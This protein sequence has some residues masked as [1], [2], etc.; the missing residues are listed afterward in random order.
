FEQESKG[1]NLLPVNFLRQMIRFYGDSMQGLVPRYLDLSMDRLMQEQQNFREQM[2]K[3]FG[4]FPLGNVEE[5]VRAN[6]AMFNEALRMFSPF[7]AGKQASA[8]G[9]P[10]ADPAREDEVS[11]LKRE[12]NAMKARLDKLDKR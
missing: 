1:E 10:V 7:Q 8:G 4:T 5:Q 9:E 3:T 12:L 2:Q 6:M 11:S